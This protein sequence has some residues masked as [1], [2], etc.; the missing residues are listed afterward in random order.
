MRTNS[1]I[2]DTFADWKSKGAC[3]D[4]DYKVF[5][6]ETKSLINMAI[7]ACNSCPVKAQ[8]LEYAMLNNERGIWGGT[9]EKRRV[10]ML[11]N[12]KVTAKK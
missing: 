1:S 9:T 3:K 11:R 7:E 12:I 6:A 5:F 8:C 2:I 4:M 10:A